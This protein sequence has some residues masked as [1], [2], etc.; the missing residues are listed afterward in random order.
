MELAK[1]QIRSRELT[2]Q[3]KDK[4]QAASQVKQSLKSIISEANEKKQELKQ[5]KPTQEVVWPKKD[6]IK[7]S[8]LPS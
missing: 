5:P 2:Q 8:K 4:I 7:E 1:E 3:L 6:T